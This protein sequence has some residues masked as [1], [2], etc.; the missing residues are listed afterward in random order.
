VQVEVA[1]RLVERN[2]TAPPSASRR[3]DLETS[4]L[5][6][7]RRARRDLKPEPG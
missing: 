7:L 2:P 6:A 5:A 3:H 1:T 4:D